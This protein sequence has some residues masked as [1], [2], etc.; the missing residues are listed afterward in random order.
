MCECLFLLIN[1]NNLR[2]SYQYSLSIIVLNLLCSRTFL[3][4]LELFF[5]KTCCLYLGKY[6]TIPFSRMSSDTTTHHA[7]DDS[8]PRRI[9]S[10][11]AVEHVGN[12][13][14]LSTT[15]YNTT[16]YR[17]TLCC[18]FLNVVRRIA[19]ISPLPPSEYI[20]QHAV[21]MKDV[22]QRHRCEN[23]SINRRRPYKNC[24]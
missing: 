7:V 9:L 4:I 16:K 12:A 21:N 11:S 2:V 23:G 10:S 6:I 13:H 20:V 17:I 3:Y 14:Y 5:Q 24:V 8:H 15:H 18:A 1:N 22:S 19:L